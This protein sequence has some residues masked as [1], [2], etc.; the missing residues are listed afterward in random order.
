MLAAALSVACTEDEDEVK[1]GVEPPTG[2]KPLVYI[3]SIWWL[4]AGHW[5]VLR[6]RMWL[7]WKREEAGKDD[8]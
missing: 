8:R 6:R 7:R 1:L 4:T 5:R 2:R 3:L